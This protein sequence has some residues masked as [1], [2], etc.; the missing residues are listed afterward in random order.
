M[1]LY[2]YSNGLYK[3]LKDISEEKSGI[4]FTTSADGYNGQSWLFRYNVEIN[5]A[6][7]NLNERKFD[8][9]TSEIR[10]YIYNAE[11]LDY[12]SVVCL[13]P[14]FAPLVEGIKEF[15][16]MIDITDFSVLADSEWFRIF[17]RRCCGDTASLLWK[18][19]Q[20]K[21][22]GRYDESIQYCNGMKNIQSHA[23]L[24][25]KRE[26]I[27]DITADQFLD[28]NEPVIITTEREFYDKF[29]RLGGEMY[30]EPDFYNYQKENRDRLLRIYKLICTGKK[31]E[32][33]YG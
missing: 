33:C 1:K 13:N 30:I 24:E 3:K 7:P 15:R 8:A 31:N 19:L 10:W 29:K 26:I 22:N 6:D 32:Y 23:W 2:H 27:I 11:E 25:Y 4:W 16:A 28:I 21:F 17:P 14:E 9:N 20:I 5:E 12:D 18:Y